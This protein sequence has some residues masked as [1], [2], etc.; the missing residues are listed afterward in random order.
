MRSLATELAER[1]RP[2]EPDVIC[3]P[4][5]EGAFVGL[6]VADTLQIE[7]V[8]AERQIKRDASLLYPAKYRIPETLRNLENRRVAIA[9]DVINAGSAVRGALFDLEAC[10][11]SVVALGALLVLGSHAGEL[12]ESAAIPLARISHHLT[13]KVR[14]R[15][16]TT[17][18]R[19]I[20]V[21]DG[22]SSTPPRVDRR[23]PRTD[24][25]LTHF[26]SPRGEKCGLETLETKPNSVWAPNE[27]PLCAAGVALTNFR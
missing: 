20:V 22:L 13:A 4:L 8:Y 17:S 23:P 25:P 10:G 1:L 18:L 12:A 21:L 16:A 9:N 24:A 11:A 26:R 5:V 7:F 15:C 2:H 19:S 14:D 6:F 27:C 3:G